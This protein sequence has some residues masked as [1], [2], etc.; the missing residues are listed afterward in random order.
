MSSVPGPGLSVPRAIPV[1]RWI[2]LA[3]LAVAAAASILGLPRAV[4]A[5]WPGWVRLVPVGL[6]AI[7]VAGY[8]AYR[9]ALVRAGRY[10]AG[11]A[12]VRVGL[13]LLLLGVIAGIALERPPTAPSGAALDLAGP[14]AAEDPALRALAAEVARSRPQAEGR[15]H[16]A[17]LA[18][19]V[20]DPSAEVRHQAR[21]SLGALVGDDAGEGA[22]A[23]ARWLELCRARGLLPAAR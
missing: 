16:L 1:L 9:L 20:E 11:K 6:L 18:A 5:G 4:E 19:L 23:T 7:F 8:A 3:V 10:S 12:M 17:R 13:M 2:L 14:L 21:A 15:R 22:G